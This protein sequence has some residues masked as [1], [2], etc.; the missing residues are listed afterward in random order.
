MVALLPAQPGDYSVA[1]LPAQD[2]FYT[3][4]APGG[5]RYECRA[6]LGVVRVRRPLCLLGCASSALRGCDLR[7]S[8]CRVGFASIHQLLR[9][10]DKARSLRSLPMRG[11]VLSKARWVRRGL[12]SEGFRSVRRRREE[13]LRP[14]RRRHANNPISY[15]PCNS[16]GQ[17]NADRPGGASLD[18]SP[19]RARRTPIE[20]RSKTRANP[21]FLG[22]SHGRP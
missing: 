22:E 3:R 5:L 12:F 15:G 10:S 21:G 1:P 8:L 7:P 20:G 18:P 16:K 19:G 6:C 14:T 2:D 11:S 4:P 13:T 17:L 9:C